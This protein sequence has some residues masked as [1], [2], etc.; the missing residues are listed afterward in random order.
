MTVRPAARLRRRR[1][2][3]RRYDRLRR[4]RRRGFFDLVRLLLRH[5]RYFGLIDG[6]VGRG[7]INR[8]R[9]VGIADFIS[10][11]SPK[12]NARYQK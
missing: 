2:V 7:E 4:L 5:R 1:F 6:V 3:R 8:Q 11:V 9:R 12:T 10:S